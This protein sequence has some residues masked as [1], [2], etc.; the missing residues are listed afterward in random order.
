MSLANQKTKRLLSKIC[1]QPIAVITKNYGESDFFFT[2]WL[3]LQVC[4]NFSMETRVLKKGSMTLG[5]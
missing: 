1:Q 2:S 4:D 3:R 5:C